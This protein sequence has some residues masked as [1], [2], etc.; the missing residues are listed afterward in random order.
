MVA[1]VLTTGSTVTCA[2]PPGTVTLSSS[3]TLHVAGV[4]VVRAVDTAGAVIA[5]PENTKCASIVASPSAILHDG[6]SPVVLVTDL[7][8]NIGTCT[9]T[10]NHDLLHTE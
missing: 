7:K 4:P 2:H 9:V 8:T 6:G 1:K 5:C 10:A 3:A